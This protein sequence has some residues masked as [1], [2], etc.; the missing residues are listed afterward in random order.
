MFI[1]PTITRQKLQRAKQ[2]SRNVALLRSSNINR[3][4]Y[5]HHPYGINV[6]QSLQKKFGLPTDSAGRRE[7][8]R[9][10]NLMRRT[11]PTWRLRSTRVV[12]NYAILATIHG[13]SIAVGCALLGIFHMRRVSG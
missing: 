1:A 10:G 5:K 4:C 12:S 2:V 7:S 11:H 13:Q 6:S 8:L 3:E 9:L